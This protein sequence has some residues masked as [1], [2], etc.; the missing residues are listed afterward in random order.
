MLRAAKAAA[1]PEAA[2]ARLIAGD[3]NYGVR[4]GGV[5]AD[6]VSALLSRVT[7]EL[8]SLCCGRELLLAPA[9]AQFWRAPTDNDIANGFVLRA[10]RW[11]LASLYP[12]PAS[13]DADTDGGRV[14]VRYAA[15][16]E[17]AFTVTYRF[18][19]D[20][21]LTLKLCVP[22]TAGELPCMG[23]E[24]I[25]PKDVSHIAW[26]GNDAHCAAP[27]RRNARRLA[28]C[29]SD[30]QTEYVPYPRPQMNAV[31]TDVRY[32]VLTDA[33][34]NGLRAAAEAPFCFAALPWT[35]HEIEQ[36][37]DTSM[38]PPPD[39][40]VLSLYG[41]MRGVGG[42]D[43]WGADVHAPYRVHAAHG[44]TCAFHLTPVFAKEKR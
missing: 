2:P 36:A 5:R 8:Y 16:G 24:L 27:D 10:A 1:R 43:T 15:A 19:A 6:G 42:D 32:V 9:Q 40:T 34:G 17:T 20:G 18:F 30:V 39:K 41:A 31:K 14:A 13:I 28:A 29:A 25:L 38:L 26:Y 12:Y 21:S 33:K 35:C 22:P 44:L 23:F 4:T 3:A 7:G 11:K 37:H